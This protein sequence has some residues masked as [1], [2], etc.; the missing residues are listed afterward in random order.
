MKIETWKI[1]GHKV[2]YIDQTH[3]YIV[4]GIITPSVT[5]ILKMVFPGKYD[6]VDKATLE[7]ASR[8]G[9]LLHSIIEEY[10]NE[11]ITPKI[12]RQMAKGGHITQEFK[13]YIYLKKNFNYAPVQNEVPIIFE[14]PDGTV[15]FAGRLDMIALFENLYCIFDIKRT[16]FLDVKYLRLQLNLYRLAFQQCYGINIDRLYALYLR[17]ENRA[18]K[19]I[20]VNEAEALA[21]IEQWKRYKHEVNCKRKKP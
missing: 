13:N 2:E 9:T 18:L 8:K 4:D 16:Y 1:K 15:I 21:V 10:E 19:K 7:S 12:T 3:T 17:N 20:E 11:G 5:Q 14:D 6:G